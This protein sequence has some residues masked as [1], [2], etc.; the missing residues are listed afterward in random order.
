MIKRPPGDLRRS[1]G[2]VGVGGP[3]SGLQI[4]AEA[5]LCFYS[6]IFIHVAVVGGAVNVLVGGAGPS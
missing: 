1:S 2:S 3:N 6:H 5:F 4:A